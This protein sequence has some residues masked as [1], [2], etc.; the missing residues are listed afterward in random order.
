[1]IEI[2]WLPVACPERKPVDHL[3][4]HPKGEALVTEPEPDLD[5]S[6]ERCHE[7]LLSL[8]PS[9][10]LRKAGVLSGDFRLRR[11]L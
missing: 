5:A 6:L 2:R 9:Q 3:W 8:K 10:L 4:R 7:Y 11:V 1:V